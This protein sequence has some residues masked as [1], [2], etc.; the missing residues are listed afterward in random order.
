MLEMLTSNVQ[1]C[2]VNSDV[3]DLDS[4]LVCIEARLSDDCHDGICAKM[5][6]AGAP[7]PGDVGSSTPMGE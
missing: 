6:D 4:Y 3:Y 2:T 7:C 5:A 1:V